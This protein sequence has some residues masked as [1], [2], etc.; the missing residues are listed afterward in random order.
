MAIETSISPSSIAYNRFGLGA[1][2]DDPVANDPKRWLVD[3]IGNYDPK[4]PLVASLPSTASLAEDYVE[5]RKAA[6]AD[7]DAKTRQEAQAALRKDSRS[8]YRDAVNARIDNALATPTP[9]AERLVHF[10]SNHFAVSV[11]K[12]TVVPFAGSFEAE[13]IRPNIMRNFA[14]LV[15]A[16][17]S[18]AAMLLYLDQAQSVGPNSVQ[19]QRAKARNAVRVPGL[20]ENLAREILELHTL[21][22]RSGYTQ[23][24]VTE[25]ARALTG[26]SIG[27][28]AGNQP[29][30]NAVET[31]P[32]EFVF[33]DLVH[34]PGIRIILDREYSQPG[35]E[36]AAEVL[37]TVSTSTAAGT[38][39]ARKLATHFAGDSPPQALV[40]RLSAAFNKTRGNL[41]AV[42]RAL[43][44]SPEVWV[45]Q[46][47]KF[48]TPWDWA[49]SSFRAT[50]QRSLGKTPGVDVMTQLGQRV[51]QP[52]SPAGWDDVAA[53]W[54]APDALV[55]R[56]VMANR[57]AASVG[58]QYDPRD[59]ATRIQIGPLSPTTRGVIAGAESRIAGFALLLVSPE[60]QRR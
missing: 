60:F 32:G 25:F 59:L 9:F 58:D 40:D 17:E 53:S 37:R 26:W 15:M 42:Y 3:Q 49:I 29:A 22:V 23:N 51:W 36:Q 35:V 55:R 38:H 1:R 31:A 54:A 48:K 56:A 19:A 12:G 10:W 11:D 34:E 24:D 21:G 2:P 57:L 44:E 43:I 52:G 14:D 6:R 41:P 16:A 39:I 30:R 50:G 46:P 20:N 45:G 47:L 28:I 5:Q 4:P 18:H 13:A 33:R 8:Q 7:D 27:S